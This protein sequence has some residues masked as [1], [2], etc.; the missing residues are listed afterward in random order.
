VEFFWQRVKEST[1]QESGVLLNESEDIYR[2]EGC[3]E[4]LLRECGAILIEL[5]VFSFPPLFCG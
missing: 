3:L 2:I 5:R 4:S 1:F